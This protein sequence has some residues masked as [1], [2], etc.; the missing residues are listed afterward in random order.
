MLDSKLFQLRIISFLEGLS[1]LGLLFIAMPIKYIGDNPLYVKYFG[2]AHGMLFIIFIYALYNAWN[3]YRWSIKFTS[4]AFVCSVL[5][6]APFYLEKRL[7]S[8]HVKTK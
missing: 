4:F 5:P 8:L 1:F 3:E 2:M 6:F 7:K